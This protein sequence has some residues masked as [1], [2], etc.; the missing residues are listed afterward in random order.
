MREYI[1]YSYGHVT[2]LMSFK[3]KQMADWKSYK[4]KLENMIKQVAVQLDSNDKNLKSYMTK[5]LEASESS[6]NKEITDLNYKINDVKIENHKHALNLQNCAKELTVEYNKFPEIKSDIAKQ[7]DD[8]VNKMKES[9]SST[10]DS[11]DTV[12]QDFEMIKK[13]FLDLSE[14]I[15]D[16]RFR[17][18]LGADVGRQEFKQMAGQLARKD[19]KSP[20]I[21]RLKKKKTTVHL[22]RDHYEEKDCDIESYVKKYINSVTSKTI[23]HDKSPKTFKNRKAQMDL[24]RPDRTDEKGKT[25]NESID[26][27]SSE[28]FDENTI[29]DK[30]NQ[31]EDNNLMR[32][33][34]KDI[35]NTSFD[36]K[37]NNPNDIIF[38]KCKS[39]VSKFKDKFPLNASK[40]NNIDY[41][42][43]SRVNLEKNRET[44]KTN[45]LG[46]NSDEILSNFQNFTKIFLEFKSDF[47][48]K[49][50]FT[51]K[52]L[53]EMENNSR[54]KLEELEAR[55][56][57]IDNI[58]NNPK[59][60]PNNFD[61]KLSKFQDLDH[62]VKKS[63]SNNENNSYVHKTNDS[64]DNTISDTNHNQNFNATSNRIYSNNHANRMN[65]M[66]PLENDKNYIVN[67]IN[68]SVFAKNS[69]ESRTRDEK[70]NSDNMN[71]YNQSNKVNNSRVRQRN[72]S[73]NYSHYRINDTFLQYGSQK[74]INQLHSQNK[75]K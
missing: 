36:S 61:K 7:M 71:E 66:T 55:L 39:N 4:D 28:D 21:E 58:S 47:G 34:S 57:H 67:I 43:N 18:N 32:K 63:F 26:E 70:I 33:T 3:D 65:L 23:E 27:I 54:K 38:K 17:K 48:Q 13:K 64:N 69:Q 40:S 45:S 49:Y 8:A 59:I 20:E 41:D 68:P 51:E 62:T 5:L 72:T 9:H 15:K 35:E 11:F 22:N 42:A 31:D 12:K 73:N 1:D 46:D 74:P 50:A 14:F 10:V 30:N 52:K 29:N 16:V 75:P 56:K 25:Q 60:L 53:L 6:Y 24:N 37:S 44:T 19:H 2:S